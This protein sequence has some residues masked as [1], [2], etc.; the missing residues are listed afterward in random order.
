MSD[1][2]IDGEN[3]P[4]WEIAQDDVA[5]L[6]ERALD[7]GR[8]STFEEDEDAPAYAL[9]FLENSKGE[10]GWVIITAQGHSW[11]GLR[12]DVSEI[13]EKRKEAEGEIASRLCD[14]EDRYNERREEENEEEEE[15]E[16]DGD[17]DSEGDEDD[18][19]KHD[20]T[21]PASGH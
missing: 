15:E 3:R 2:E 5:S 7:S 21:E 8:V 13:F 14:D 6:Y 1:D 20:G 11:E 4:L 19:R 9:C 12:Y 18:G 17:D 16:E 10:K